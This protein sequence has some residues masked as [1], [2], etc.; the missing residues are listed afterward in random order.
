M[1]KKS[2]TYL[3]EKETVHHLNDSQ[4]QFPGKCEEKKTYNRNIFVSLQQ[5]QQ[6]QQLQTNFS[7]PDLENNVM[8]TKTKPTCLLKMVLPRFW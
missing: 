7:L 5:Q 8:V 6:Q 4:I 2:V 3:T 1:K